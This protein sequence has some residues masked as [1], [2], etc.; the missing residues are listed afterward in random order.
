MIKKIIFILA[1]FVSTLFSADVNWA[2]DYHKAITNAQKEGKPIMFIISR[3]TCRYCILLKDTTL[4]D[5][6]VVKAL[7]KDF[8]SS[9]AWIN[10]KDFIP[11]ELRYNTPGLPGI[12]FLQPDGE[13]MFNPLMGYVEKEK[14]LEALGIV[15]EEFKNINKGKK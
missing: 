8:I 7:N 4:K 15:K 9:V 14:F 10:E 13:P 5:E 2:Q 11:E 12:W 3:D 1:V 6:K